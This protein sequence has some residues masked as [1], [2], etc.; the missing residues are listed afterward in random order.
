[1][2]TQFHIKQIMS[3]LD[4]QTALISN[5]QIAPKTQ[6]TETYKNTIKIKPI[7]WQK[8]MYSKTES[9]ARNKNKESTHY[10]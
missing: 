10:L 8:I 3:N 9:I 4:D 2:Q 7:Q 5:V 1:M 6:M